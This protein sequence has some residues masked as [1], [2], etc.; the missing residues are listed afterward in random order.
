MSGNPQSKPAQSS[1][2]RANEDV[3]GRFPFDDTKDMDDARRGFMG[4]AQ[5][6]EIAGAGG[7][8]VWDLDAYGFLTQDCPSTA[9]R[10]CGGRAVWSPSTDCSRSW[11][12]ST[13]S[14]DSTC[15]T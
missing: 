15:R 1:I 10:A 5:S 3:L 7:T 6:S 14:A 13:R 2:S 12:A 11:R 4:T 9:I 8:A